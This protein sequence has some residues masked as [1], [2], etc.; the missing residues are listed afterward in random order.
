MEIKTEYPLKTLNTFNIKVDAKYFMEVA[1]PADIRQGVDFAKTQN[2]PLLVLGGGS[3][4]LF[5]KNFDGLVMKVNVNG[6]KI[7]REDEDFVFVKVGAGEIWD[8]FVAYCVE[9]NMAGL[10]NLSLIPGNVGASPVQNIGAYGVEMKDLFESLEYF[11]FE[12][13]KTI[14]FTN[15]ECQFGYRNSIFKKKKKGKG[16][17]L[18]VTFKLRKIPEFKTAY[19]AIREEL[20][21]L[22]V[23]KPTLKA[24]R[25]AVINIRNS[26]L[27][28]PEEIGN[29]GSFFKN[30]TVPAEIH[31]LLAGEHPGLVSYPQAK[32]AYKLAAG[33]LIDQCGWKGY[34]KGDAGVHE[35]QALVLVNYNNATG[36][37]IYELSQNIKESVMNTFHVELEREVN[38]I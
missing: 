6:V 26:K 30:P 13:G 11:E 35:N 1:S 19:G 29:A 37:E 14:N 38:V 20:T 31:N 34:R 18:S 22:G 5:T 2:I 28:D 8:D 4:L 7:V 3:N 24:M 21:R 23:D 25:N 27:P 17:V 33:W 9:N 10:E 15:S 12:T 36:R 16:L 32:N